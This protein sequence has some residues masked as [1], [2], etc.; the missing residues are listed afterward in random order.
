MPHFPPWKWA[1]GDVRRLHT[2]FEQYSNRFIVEMLDIFPLFGDFKFVAKENPALQIIGECKSGHCEFELGGDNPRGAPYMR[3]SQYAKGFEGRKIFRWATQWDFLFTI[4]SKNEQ[5]ALLI[6]RDLV[7]PFW[8]NKVPVGEPWL[9]WPVNSADIFVLK[10]CLIDLSSPSQLVADMER[11]LDFTKNLTKSVKAK[12]AVPIFPYYHDYVDEDYNEGGS[13]T[14][15]RH[16]EVIRPDGPVWGPRQWST[17]LYRRGFGS[18]LHGSMRGTTYE[19][20]S[21]EVV[22]QL[23]RQRFVP[24]R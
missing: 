16:K 11:V 19:F 22:T 20:W 10:E 23:C 13:P 18:H 3:H 9:W 12:H 7:P 21:A 6:A 24:T 17:G 4:N 15:V 8:W 1:M 14:R 5:Q 2:A